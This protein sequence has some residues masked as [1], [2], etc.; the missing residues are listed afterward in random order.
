MTSE[1]L[2]SCTYETTVVRDQILLGD[3]EKYG[4]ITVIDTPGYGDPK[5]DYENTKNLVRVLKETKYVNAFYWVWNS[6]IVKFN[7]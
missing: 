5:G 4:R 2:N 3:E 1:A 7:I 6:R